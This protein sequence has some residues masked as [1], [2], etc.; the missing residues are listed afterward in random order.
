MSDFYDTDYTDSFYND[1][2][3]DQLAEREAWE[4]ARA[5][6]HDFEDENEEDPEDFDFGMDEIE[7]FVDTDSPV[8]DFDYEEEEE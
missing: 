3:L 6:M 4:D 7:D 8:Y 2:D 5:E 1:D